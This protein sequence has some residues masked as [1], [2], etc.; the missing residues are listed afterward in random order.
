ME[1]PLRDRGL[2]HDEV[3]TLDLY[4]LSTTRQKGKERNSNRNKDKERQ[5]QLQWKMRD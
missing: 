4:L 2:S 5:Q 1:Y 3:T